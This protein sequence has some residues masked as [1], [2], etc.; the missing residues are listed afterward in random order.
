[1]LVDRHP[2]QRVEAVVG[3]LDGVEALRALAIAWVVLFHWL[4]VR[5][6]AVADPWVQWIRATHWANAFVANGYLGVDLF[7]LIT[8]FLLVLPWARAARD[9]SPAPAARDFYVRR[10]RRIVPAY[11]LQLAVLFALVLPLAWGMPQVREQ[12]A[13][14][15]GNLLAHATFLHY[16]TPLTS[17]SLSLNGALWSLTLEAEFYLLLPLLA[18]AFVRRPLL[19]ALAMF[20][21]AAAWRWAAMH[22]LS[23][24]VA[25]EMQLGARWNV[26]EPTIR[27][28]LLTQ[29]PG[30]LGHFAVGMALGVVLVR[31]GLRRRAG[32][33]GLLALGIG[34]LAWAYGAGAGAVLGVVGS[35]LATLAALACVF[36]AFLCSAGVLHRALTSRLVVGLGLASYST[37]LYHLPIL[38]LWNRFRML[39]GSAW[40]L[41]AYLACV[42]LA[43]WGSYR[44]VERPFL[45]R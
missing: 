32:A 37:Y 27:H 1:M 14:I 7:F 12:A 30:Y 3:H 34:I 11:S 33:W 41:P 9:R 43:A 6:A 29:L 35:W 20:G 44:F 15:A 2:E 45:R 24:L 40:S 31:R 8:G 17:A 13:L 39:E 22:D 38:V 28:L 18:P 19:A 16:T 42:L 26:P 5:E 10:I 21:L 25:W 4:V 23:W 36:V